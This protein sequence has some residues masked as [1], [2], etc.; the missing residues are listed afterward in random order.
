MRLRAPHRRTLLAITLLASGGIFGSDYP[1]SSAQ[2][3]T[4]KLPEPTANNP[5]TAASQLA[6]GNAQASQM[7]GMLSKHEMRGKAWCHE[8]SASPTLTDVPPLL[9]HYGITHDKTVMGL[10]NV[11]G[12]ALLGDHL[13]LI[14]RTGGYIGRS[15]MDKGGS[16]SRTSDLL[17]D[18]SLALTSRTATGYGLSISY[19][20]TN[21]SR[22]P[23]GNVEKGVL[24]GQYLE[25]ALYVPTCS[26]PNGCKTHIRLGNTGADLWFDIQNSDDKSSGPS[27]TATP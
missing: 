25:Q 21:P 19:K 9:V 24:L 12:V 27:A 26:I 14:Y 2:A 6:I 7:V 4:I 10:S 13:P 3:E 15:L 20:L 11:E 18:F 5:V 8:A 23:K 22:D 1:L 16:L 17:E